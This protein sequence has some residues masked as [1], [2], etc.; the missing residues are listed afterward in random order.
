MIHSVGLGVAHA[1]AHL[2][3]RRHHAVPLHCSWPAT[4]ASG[5]RGGEESARSEYTNDTAAESL[6]A[7]SAEMDV[8]RRA[9]ETTNICNI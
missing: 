5:L 4:K 1:V 3:V 8:N 7:G 2:L 9:T 6:G